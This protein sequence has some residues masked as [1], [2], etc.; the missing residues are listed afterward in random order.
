MMLI[1]DFEILYGFTCQYSLLGVIWTC[2][3]HFN[4]N[5]PKSFL[6]YQV[7]QDVYVHYKI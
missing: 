7:G 3:C 5:Y 6:L 4:N 2:F 1:N